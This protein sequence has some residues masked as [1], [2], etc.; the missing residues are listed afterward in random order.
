V[1]CEL[2]ELAVAA[3]APR[4][5]ALASA[6]RAREGNG[7]SGVRGRLV[8]HYEHAR[9]MWRK[10]RAWTPRGGRSLN[11]STTTFTDLPES[12]SDDRLIG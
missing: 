11:R 1:A 8:L 2:S 6:A 3:A 12:S 9:A 4:C 5:S 10:G 7:G